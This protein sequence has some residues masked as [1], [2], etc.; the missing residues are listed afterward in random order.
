M[1]VGWKR[2]Y[3][4]DAVYWF[5][6]AVMFFAANAPGDEWLQSF[7]RKTRLR[8]IM[9]MHRF[10]EDMSRENI[11]H[12]RLEEC[13]LCMR[14]HDETRPCEQVEGR[15]CVY[16][17]PEENIRAVKRVFGEEAT[18]FYDYA[19]RHRDLLEVKEAEACT[20]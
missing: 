17:T 9:E 10:S 4:T 7:A 14:W 13:R 6:R 16:N 15:E 1:S 5:C 3:D 20:R 11:V 2:Q 19:R 18:R 8:A 12:D